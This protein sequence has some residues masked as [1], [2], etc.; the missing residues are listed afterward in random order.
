MKMR[1]K[2]ISFFDYVVEYSLYGMIFFIPISKAAIEIFFAF[3][4]TAFLF[5]KILKP[6]YEFLSEPTH[7]FLLYLFLLLFIS[8]SGLSLINS[9]PYF[10]KGLMSLFFKWGEYILIFI[11]I[12]GAFTTYKRV[13][14]ALFI[15]LS[16]SFLVMIDGLWQYFF[17]FEFLRHR[18]LV[19]VVNNTYA[20]TASFNHYNDFGAYLVIILSLVLA[21]FISSQKN[22]HKL[23]LFLL[24]TLLEICLL[25]TFSRGSWIGFI[26]LFFLMLFISRKFKELIPMFGIFIILLISLPLIR[27]RWAFI[28]KIGGDADRLIVWRA[29]LDTIKE[30]PFLGKGIGTFMDYFSK[31]VPNLSVQYAHNCFL[32]IWAE[33]GIFSLLSFLAFV[34]LL[35]S[36]G[37]IAFKR[38]NN[39]IALGLFCGIFGFLVHSFFD[40]HLYSLQLSALFWSMAGI[41]V[42]TIKLETDASK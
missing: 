29:A 9:G 8:F 26:S 36:R 14:N 22:L 11:I 24:V 37:I 23:A 40:T 25:L 30:N 21:L 41:L 27:Q 16:V 10:V 17:A 3:A 33:T 18:S 13:R 7:P 5:K 1:E 6:D 28:F 19:G 15:L 39:Y 12:S 34:I 42:A 38:N 32:Q 2:W 31:R 20:I 4:F 35:L